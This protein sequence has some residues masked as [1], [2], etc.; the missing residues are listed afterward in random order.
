MKF[1]EKTNLKIN[2]KAMKI[3]F[4]LVIV[5]FCLLSNIFSDKEPKEQDSNNQ[6]TT[7]SEQTEEFNF[8]EEIN[9]GTSN[10]VVFCG[11]AIAL[12]V[13][14]YKKTKIPNRDEGRKEKGE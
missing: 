2:P 7:T 4:A 3:I 11:L 12:G 5:G 14:K 6:T 13:V 9:I 10:I 8:W 1:F